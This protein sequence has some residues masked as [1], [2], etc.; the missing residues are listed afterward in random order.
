M[1]RWDEAWGMWHGGMTVAGYE[2]AGMT[3][4]MPAPLIPMSSS[5]HA[6]CRL[7]HPVL[8]PAFA[9]FERVRRAPRRE[10]MDPQWRR[11]KR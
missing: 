7:P 3:I 11:E 6:A 2:W 1:E 10:A 8:L 4:A 5:P 9:K